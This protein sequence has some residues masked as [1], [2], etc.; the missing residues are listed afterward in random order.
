[1]AAAIVF[2]SCAPAEKEPIRVE[3]GPSPS[4]LEA[5]LTGGG[6]DLK[7]K[8]NRDESTLIQG[9]NIYVSEQP[10]YQ[11]GGEKSVPDDLSPVNDTP[12]PGDVDPGYD[13]ETYELRGLENGKIHYVAVTTLYSGDVESQPTN[14]IEIIPRPEGTFVLNSSFSG[15][16]DGYSFQRQQ[17]VATDDLDND[18]Y[19][20]TIDE[21]L[22]VA[23]P[24]R[25]DYVLRETSFY[26]IG[27]KGSLDEVRVGE[28]KTRP[29]EKLKVEEGLIFL[30]QDAD[31][32]YALVKFDIADPEARRVV[33]S[34]I[35]QSKP[36]ALRF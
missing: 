19:L 28:L 9:Y 2:L 14:Q 8:T 5:D 22:Y 1:V 26:D 32:C 13:F 6:A 17:S 21:D 29:S 24:S 20:T 25:I 3:A 31:D 10:L 36:N 12:Y 18:I 15:E 16:Q 30:L 34:Y 27:R 33:S 4:E 11:P 35:Y 23:S 7:W